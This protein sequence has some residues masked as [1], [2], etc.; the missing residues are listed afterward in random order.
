M[1]RNERKLYIN[2]SRTNISKKINEENS[3]DNKKLLKLKKLE[4]K[5]N[6]IKHVDINNNKSYNLNISK[7]K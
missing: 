2:N 3:K 5:F 1:S 6:N 4:Y 7:K